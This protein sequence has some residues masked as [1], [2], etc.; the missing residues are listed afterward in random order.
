[1][2]SEFT[3]VQKLKKQRNLSKRGL[4]GQYDNTLKAIEFY[5]GDTMSYEDRIEFMDGEGDKKRATVQFNKVQPNVEAVGGFMAQNRRQAKFSARLP[6]N[7][8]ANVYSKNMNACY[9]Y[10]RENTNADQLETEQ[11]LDML[12]NGYGAIETD[13]S[14]IIGRATT[15]P[16]GEIIKVKLDPMKIGW[17][18]ASKSKNL[19]DRRWN[20]Y[21]DDYELKDAL[22]LF[23]A[24]KEEDFERVGDDDEAETGYVFNPWGGLYDKI[25]AEDSVEWASASE[26]MV[27]VY[28]HQ[29]FEYE[30]FY[31]AD[32]PLYAT[33]EVNDALFIQSRLQN[34]LSQIKDDYEGPDGME[35]EDMFTF[36]PAAEQLTFNESTK[37]LLVKEFGSL[38]TPVPFKRKCFYTA[39]YSGDHIFAK[40]KSICQ[41]GF[42]VNFKTGIYNAAQRLW[43]G[44]VNAM[45]EPAEYH[46]KAL[47][48]L[49]F[50][51]S[52]NSKGGVYLE[53]DAVEDIA[54]FED[55]NAKTDAVIIVRSGALAAGK[56]QDKTRP[57]VPTGLENI[58]ML[59]E[60]SIADNGV[61]PAFMGN[62]EKQDQ[63]G[64]LFK[65]RIRQVIS[66][67][68]RYFDSITLSQKEDARLMEDLIPVWAENNKG[69]Y[70]KITGDDNQE[71]YKQITEDMFAA[72]YDVTI[73]E[74]PESPEDKQET[75]ELLG[76][77]GD[78]LAAT[79]NMSAASAFYAESVKSLPRLDSNSRNILLQ[80][81]Q[82]QG[83]K[84]DPAYVQQ[85]EQ[86]LQQLTSEA[87]QIENDK[88]KADAQYSQARAQQTMA[89]IEATK[90]KAPQIQAQTVKTLEEARRTAAETDTIP[91]VE[92]DKVSVNV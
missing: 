25:K 73:E 70:Y 21:F 28:N 8:Q 17:D 29:W 9:A 34:I 7:E 77:Y 22:S 16:Y 83:P 13:L 50:T 32:N 1:M 91:E 35:V 36:N 67:F 75:A 46:N 3:L 45:M 52:M 72:E 64:I 59:S 23:Q 12:I 40:F 33:E 18:A 2:T 61:D 68:A 39:V 56:I 74:A 63:S 48:E 15:N 92:P 37:K 79:G 4:S 85:L 14:Y 53:E 41:Q 84:I 66:K 43:V 88:K 24:S 87:A 89:N 69:A 31:V 57:A 90:L 60:K 49:M 27:R 82:P 55:N 44:M 5:N 54:E 38:I 30:T 42:S 47:T 51:I 86:Q 65:R 20:Y 76:T 81:L 19:M 71:Q 26:D 78:K 62:I 6:D 10:H 11:D 58:I 80:S